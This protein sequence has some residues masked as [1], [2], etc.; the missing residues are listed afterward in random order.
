MFFLVGVLVSS[1]GYSE[2]VIRDLSSTD[3]TTIRVHTSLIPS[4]P[5][6]NMVTLKTTAMEKNG[7]CAK[8]GF[9][10]LDENQATYSAM[11][12]TYIAK[13]DISLQ[14]DSEIGINGAES[15]TNYC[16]ILYFD[17]KN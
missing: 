12:A 2:S 15:S 6:K 11:L 14:Y 3:I 8:G 16:A 4:D 13:K 5:L 10:P 9:L 7:K 1:L 17:V